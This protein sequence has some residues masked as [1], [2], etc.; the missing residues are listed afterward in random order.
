MQL[1]TV[2]YYR[3]KNKLEFM[4]GDK[5]ILPKEKKI[6]GYPVSGQ[7]RIRHPY[8]PKTSGSDPD[9]DPDGSGFF[10]RSGSGF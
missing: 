10:R 5:N 9:L 1:I 4:K 2:V 3:T 7:I 6:A 8:I